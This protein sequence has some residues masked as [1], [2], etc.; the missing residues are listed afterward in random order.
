MKIISLMILLPALL[1][2]LPTASAIPTSVSGTFAGTG[3]QLIS[4]RTAGGNT[5]TTAT[6]T[7]TLTGG[8]TGSVVETY[9]LLTTSKGLM[10]Y[11]GPVRAT[12]TGT[13]NGVPGTTVF[14]VTANSAGGTFHGHFTILSGTDGLARLR[15]QGT[16]TSTSASGG[17]YSGQI[18]LD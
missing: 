15:G 7:F 11:V 16:F 14:R 13:V 10:V 2:L 4:S 3:Y 9:T 6:S 5:F 17:T 12:F 1:M 8:F 18:I